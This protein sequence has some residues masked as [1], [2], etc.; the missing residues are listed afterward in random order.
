MHEAVNEWK[1][2]SAEA[3]NISTLT[4][5]FLPKLQ[6]VEASLIQWAENQESATLSIMMC[7]CDAKQDLVG[8]LKRR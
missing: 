5:E 3:M 8:E 4:L 1:D 6:D 7:I 2:G